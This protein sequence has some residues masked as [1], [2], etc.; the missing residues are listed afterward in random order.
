ME[1]KVTMTI[2]EYSVKK[3]YLAVGGVEGMLFFFD[4]LSKIKLGQSHRHLHEI[5]SLF[6]IDKQQ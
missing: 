2:C 3:G 6:F 5:L 1:L 4:M